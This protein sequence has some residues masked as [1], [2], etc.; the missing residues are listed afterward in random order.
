MITYITLF[1]S[2]N[3]GGNNILPMK[4]LVKILEGLG[5]KNIKTYIQS[6]NVVFQFKKE[7]QTKIAEQISLEVLEL[8][9]FKPEVFLLESADLQEAIKNNPF[10]VKNGKDLHF[11]FLES[12][13]VAP[14]LKSLEAIKTNTEE[15]KLGKKVFYFY[16][17]DGIGRSKLASKV[18]RSLKVQTTARNWNTVSKL[19][20][21]VSQS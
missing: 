11:Y 14:D 20:E 15:F 1:R 8:F 10:E 17:P 4:G 19:I 13:P 2:I 21:M 6:G 5:C 3:V 16:A 7:S 12:H 18:Q 9:Q